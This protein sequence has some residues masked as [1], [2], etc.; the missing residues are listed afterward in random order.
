MIAVEDPGSREPPGAPRHG[1]HLV[2]RHT[3]QQGTWD[4]ETRRLI[5]SVRSAPLLARCGGPYPDDPLVETVSWKRAKEILSSYELD[6]SPQFMLDKRM[7]RAARM[8][9]SQAA[10]GVGL[11]RRVFRNPDD[12][13]EAT[14]RLARLREEVD[15]C[16]VENA[17][18]WSE[19]YE[20]EGGVE[21]L[22]CGLF[23][24]IAAL[25]VCGFTGM[26][27][28]LTKA[29]ALAFD[30]YLPLDLSEAEG[31]LVHVIH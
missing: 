9:D 30:G 10:K 14:R 24:S 17:R 4:A 25:A 16:V 3:L 7:V 13:N 26:F 15:G 21:N 19:M 6:T 11:W 5:T 12:Y 18:N 1:E 27:P 8:C 31:R 2:A 20:R 22:F 29:A 28:E 23:Y